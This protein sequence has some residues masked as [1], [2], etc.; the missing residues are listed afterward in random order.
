MTKRH[1]VYTTITVASGMWKYGATVSGAG[2]EVCSEKPTVSASLKLPDGTLVHI[3]AEF[4]GRGGEVRLMVPE[5]TE[6]FA[7][8]DAD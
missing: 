8:E 4:N 6:L 7:S 5:G 1:N 2:N 3:D